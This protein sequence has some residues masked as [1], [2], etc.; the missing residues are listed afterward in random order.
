MDIPHHPTTIIFHDFLKSLNLTNL[1]KEAIHKSQ[2]TLDLIITDKLSNITLKPELGQMLSDHSF[3]HCNHNMSKP[4]RKRALITQCDLK[5]IDQ[6]SLKE[7]QQAVCNHVVDPD[8]HE[9]VIEYNTNLAGILEF[10]APL[11]KRN[12]GLA[13]PNHGSM[14]E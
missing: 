6:P 5:E 9:V 10:H 3:I 12:A 11:N 1:I 7:D 4:M 14:R 8:M 13:T 2:H